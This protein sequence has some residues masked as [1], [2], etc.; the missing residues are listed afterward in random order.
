MHFTH[1]HAFYTFTCILHN[2]TITH[3]HIYTITHLHLHI[4]IYTITHFH[5]C[6]DTFA[7]AHSHFHSYV[8]RRDM[9]RHD[10]DIDIDT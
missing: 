9:T 7:F 8:T 4:C 2:Y 6:I 5:I 1:L 3:L 10:I